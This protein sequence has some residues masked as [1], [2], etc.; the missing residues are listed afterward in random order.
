[1]FFRVSGL[2]QAGPD[3]PYQAD[4][5]EFIETSPF[6]LNEARAMVA[7][8]DIEDLKTAYGLTLA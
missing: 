7:R 2:R 5:D 1:M 8:G 4:E 6:T 3:S